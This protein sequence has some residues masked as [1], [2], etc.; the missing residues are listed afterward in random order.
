MKKRV[1]ITGASGFVGYHLIEEALQHNLEV[2]VA[3]RKTSK[4]DHL[5]HLN[6]I[7][8]YPELGNII[9]LKKELKEKQ[10]DY[11]V[12]A[13]GVTTARSADEYNIINAEYTFNLA[14]AAKAT[15]INLKAF[16]LISSLAAV[17]PLNTLEGIITEETL[18]H[19]ITAYG[20]S[21]LLAEEKLKSISSL[22]YTILR[23]TAIYGPRDKDIFIFFKQLKAG[24]EPYIGYKDQKLS[25]IYV[26][27]L[28]RVAI[29]A[30]F[31]SDQRTYNLSD[32][33]FYNRY[34]LAAIAKNVLNLKTVKF[35]LPVNFVRLIALLSEK[36]GSLNNKAAVLNSEKLLELMAVNWFCEIEK[37]KYDLGY[38]PLYN[39]DSGLAETLNWYKTNKWL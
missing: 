24:I 26:K 12:H 5:K 30:L 21:K 39:L 1:L 14:A 11:I 28:A 8:T 31:T 17:G 32:G 4:V 18:P 2:F 36:V 35:H 23:P 37:A 6:I 3:V 7:F 33:N 38:Y 15:D 20:N 29:K 19:P 9:E 16:V 34:E 25:F 22:N 27:D 10:Y 13:A